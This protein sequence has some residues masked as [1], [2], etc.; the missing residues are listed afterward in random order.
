ML[1][2]T[3]ESESGEHYYIVNI[4]VETLQYSQYT[5]PPHLMNS[6]QIFKAAWDHGLLLHLLCKQ[7]LPLE[8][9]HYIN[10]LKYYLL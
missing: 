2:T 4:V 6:E 10:W 5:T 1:F 8:L 3:M 9:Q 7:L